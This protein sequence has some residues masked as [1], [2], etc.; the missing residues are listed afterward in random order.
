MQIAAEDYLKEV[1]E[2]SEEESTE[3]T[4][5]QQAAQQR[6][7]EEPL[8]RIKAAQ[9]NL[10]ELE[11]RRIEKKS[12][13]SKSIPRASTTAPEAVRIK[14]GDGGFR[15]AFNVQFASDGDTSI[16]VG[17]SV[18]NQGSDQDQMIPMYQFVCSTYDVT[19]GQYMVDG[20]FT[21]ATDIDAMDAAGTK[22]FGTLPNVKKQIE[23][24]KDAHA[25]KPG[26]SDAMARFRARMGTAEAQEIYKQR[27][28]IAEFPNAEWRNRGL[29]QLRVRGQQKALAQTLW[30]GLVNKFHRF[31][32]L[33]F[34][35]PPSA[36]SRL[37]RERAAREFRL[38]QSTAHEPIA[39]ASTAMKLCSRSP[40]K[41]RLA[42]P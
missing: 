11:Q 13:K 16:V 38:I 41:L 39:V 19:P 9:E 29:H 8:E 25:R 35:Q 10:Q 15:P 42:K 12:R 3:A 21:K 20:G 40:A 32:Q 23:D 27:P 2:R 18:N 7:A 1:S 34:L 36:C 14:I 22:V 6:A 37:K 26:D 33:G 28:S 24:D 5:A 17:V 30:H 4:K 31:R